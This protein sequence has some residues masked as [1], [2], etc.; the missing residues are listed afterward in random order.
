MLDYKAALLQALLEGEGYSLD[1]MERVR[2]RSAGRIN[3]LQGRVSPALRA[4]E[5]DGLVRSWNGESTV[6]R[7][8]RPRRYYALT[9]EGKRIA[10]AQR[11]AIAGVVRA[12]LRYV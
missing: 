2:N 11:R 5:Q 10:Q 8:G 6:E 12:S 4:L 7:G 1:L 9:A 3:L